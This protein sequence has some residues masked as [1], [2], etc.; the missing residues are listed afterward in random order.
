MK[1]RYRKPFRYK[2]KKSVLKSRIFWLALLAIIFLGAVLYFLFFSTFFKIKDISISGNEEIASQDVEQTIKNEMFAESGNNILL[3]SPAKMKNVLLAAFPKISG[4]S[5]KRVL[6]A[7]LQVE[8]KERKPVAV[9]CKS[10]DC[11][12]VDRDGVAFEVPY[13][14]TTIPQ[15]IDQ[16]DESPI[17]LSQTVLDKDHLFSITSEIFPGLK[18]DVAI[19]VKEFILYP[20]DKLVAE[21]LGGWEI[22]FSL[23]N[24]I[25]WQLTKL[26]AVLDEKIPQNKRKDLEYIDVQFG[27]FAPYKYKN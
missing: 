27:N 17:A 15:I 14:T 12:F 2:K 8:I 25:S 1:K 24:D 7:A 20:E 21:T 18:D 22:Y 5:L 4:L 11:F 6:P 26:K 10:S 13:A 19:A 9:F 16:R 3:F 23:G